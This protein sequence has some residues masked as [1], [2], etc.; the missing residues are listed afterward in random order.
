MH[1]GGK[2]I[3]CSSALALTACAADSGELNIR[4]IADLGFQLDGTI[5]I[6]PPVIEGQKLREFVHNTHANRRLM[7]V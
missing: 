5:S 6:V 2:L 3:L 4:P 7:R 1:W